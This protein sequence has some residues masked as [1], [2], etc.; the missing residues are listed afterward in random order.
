MATLLILRYFTSQGALSTH[1]RRSALFK[2]FAL[3]SLFF[4]RACHVTRVSQDSPGAKMTYTA[5]VRVPAD[6]TALMSAVPQEQGADT[7]DT[8]TQTRTHTHR[9]TRMH[10]Q[11]VMFEVRSTTCAHIFVCVC[12][13]VCVCA[14]VCLGVPHLSDVQPDGPTKTFYFKQHVRVQTYTHTHTTHLCPLRARKKCG[15]CM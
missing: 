4:Y 15:N 13:C 12:V 2:P 10:A 5:A 1:A 11:S 6:L 14:C 3:A 8:H 7:G 9:H